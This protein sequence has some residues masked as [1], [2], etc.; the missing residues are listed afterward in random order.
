MLARAEAVSRSTAPDWW[1]DWRGEA[2]AIVASGPSTK[3]A[4]VAQL[5]GRIR[6]IAIKENAVELCSWADVVY[7]CDLPWWKHRR[8]LTSFNGLK[9]GW[10]ARIPQYFPDVKT[11]RIAEKQRNLQRHPRQYLD[12]IIVHEP[13][14][15]GAGGNSGFQALNLAVQFG[16]TR[17]VGVGFDCNGSGGAHWYGRNNWTKGNNPDEANFRRWR[18][19]FDS[20]AGRLRDLGVEFINA[21]PNSSL[22]AYPK[23][24]IPQALSVWGL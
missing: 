13:G 3:A 14:L 16:A 21:A 6:V 5:K 2:C 20:A 24:T 4:D 19:A 18:L 22:K 15:I 10:D 9:I 11:I 1:P 12:E 7:G 23:M 8:G 17:I